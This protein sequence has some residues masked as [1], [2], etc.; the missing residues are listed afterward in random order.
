[1]K[2]SVDLDDDDLGL[3]IRGA[4]NTELYLPRLDSGSE[5]ATKLTALIIFWASAH[6]AIEKARG[7]VFAFCKEH[8][9]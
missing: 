9:L 4:G 1:M 3:V 7:D 6:P 8:G 2:S 5:M